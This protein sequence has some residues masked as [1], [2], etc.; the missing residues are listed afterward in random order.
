MNESL[1]EPTCTNI[2]QSWR[3]FIADN[4]TLIQDLFKSLIL[5]FTST[6]S[7]NDPSE[8]SR[9]EES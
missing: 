8:F 7:D 1:E 2:P 4:S 9:F 3:P 5:N 6:L